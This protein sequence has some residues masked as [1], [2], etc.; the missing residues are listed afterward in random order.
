M[1]EIKY[2]KMVSNC[3][4]SQRLFLQGGLVHS[5]FRLFLEGLLVWKQERVCCGG[6]SFS[7]LPFLH[8]EFSISATYFLFFNSIAMGMQ[9]CACGSPLALTC[10]LEA[11][12]RKDFYHFLSL[13]L[14][15]KDT[16]TINI[17][18]L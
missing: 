5:S 2:P 17:L 15:Q 9:G 1:G 7:Y 8:W 13:L 11:I 10:D 6:S 4:S 14:S 18:F 12:P 3:A 16:L